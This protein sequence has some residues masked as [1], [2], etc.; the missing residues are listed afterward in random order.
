MI[1]AAL[2]FFIAQTIGWYAFNSQFVWEFWKNRPALSILTMGLPSS[3]FFWLGSKYCV[4]ATGALWSSKFISFAIGNFMFAALTW[5]HMNESPLSFKT[6]TCLSLAG[7][8][9]MIQLAME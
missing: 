8:I 9:V 4:D 1:K 5:Y 6:M 2:C 3:Y 7:L